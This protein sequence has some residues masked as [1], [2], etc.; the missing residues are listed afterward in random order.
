MK[1]I[2]IKSIPHKK[3]RYPTAGDYWEK[4]GV[5][6]I[7]SSKMNNWKYELLVTFHELI[8]Y[9]LCE[10]RGISEPSITAFD[11]EFDKKFPDKSPGE[12]KSAPYHKEHMFALKLEYMFAKQ[13]G[14]D[15]KKYEKA[16]GDLYALES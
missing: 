9:M 12:C 10:D 11:I 15:V 8:E 16:L 5:Y 7:V 13:L 1:K 3:Q 4:N 2:V 14:I 6:Y